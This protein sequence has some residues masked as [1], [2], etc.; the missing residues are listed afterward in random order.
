MG[1]LPVYRLTI[2]LLDMLWW[3]GYS[4][5]SFMTRE[6]T[7]RGC[8]RRCQGYGGRVG[9]HSGGP[10]TF[11]RNEPTVLEVKMDVY[12]FVRQIVMQITETIF[13]WV[14]FGKRTHREGV[15]RGEMMDLVRNLGRFRRLTLSV[16][17]PMAW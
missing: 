7:S 9:S 14:R 8:F 17:E 12:V 2:I 4:R 10:Y 13:R 5:G 6:L 16:W 1:C 11:L 3:G 15:L